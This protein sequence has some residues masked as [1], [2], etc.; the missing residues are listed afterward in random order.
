MGTS[1][2]GRWQD[3]NPTSCRCF[4]SWIRRMLP[5]SPLGGR[6]KIFHL[7]HRLRW[8]YSTET[9]LRVVYDSLFCEEARRKPASSRVQEGPSRH[10]PRTVGGK[11]SIVRQRPFHEGAVSEGCLCGARG[12]QLQ[13]RL[14]RTAKLTSETDRKRRRFDRPAW[15]LRKAEKRLP[16]NSLN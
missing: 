11:A 7:G 9:K 16:G 14:E 15:R 10:V 6:K 1:R 3:W 13:S 4:A 5:P 8:L 12:R 2:A